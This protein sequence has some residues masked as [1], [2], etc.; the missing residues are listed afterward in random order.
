MNNKR[1]EMLSKL[2]D[3]YDKKNKAEAFSRELAKNPITES[4]LNKLVMAMDGLTPHETFSIMRDN[5]KYMSERGL[6][7]DVP[8]TYESWSE[9]IKE[10]T[11]DHI[12]LK[13]SQLN[14]MTR[15]EFKAVSKYRMVVYPDAVAQRSEHYTYYDDRGQYKVT[16][17][18]LGIHMNNLTQRSNKVLSD[19][20]KRTIKD[21]E[22][23][24]RVA[25]NEISTILGEMDNKGYSVFR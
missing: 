15:E 17:E 11:P 10:Q 13:Q 22:K 19:G 20:E 12:R 9:E 23:S 7:K 4:E 2:K 24:Y 25:R 18:G 16:G 14:H 5:K 1:I 6:L 21:A 8:A 3:E